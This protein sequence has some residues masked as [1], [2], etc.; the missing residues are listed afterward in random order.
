MA[1]N[2][3]RL[4]IA[5]RIG[6]AQVAPRPLTQPQYTSGIVVG[7]D[8]A[9]AI[10]TQ[11]VATGLTLSFAL[12]ATAVTAG[13]AIVGN[14]QVTYTNPLTPNAPAVVVATITPQG[15]LLATN[16]TV[17][18]PVYGTV[19][20]N[21]NYNLGNIVYTPTVTNGAV[22][23]QPTSFYS[24][25]NIN[26]PITA[27]VSGINQNVGTIIYTPTY[28]AATNT[29]SLSQA[30]FIGARVVIEQNGWIFGGVPTGYN[31]S[32]NQITF[33]IGNF[34]GATPQ[35]NLPRGSPYLN[36]TNFQGNLSLAAFGLGSLGQPITGTGISPTGQYYNIATVNQP[37][38]TTTTVGTTTV[39]TITVGTS[40]YSVN[41]NNITGLY[42]TT[43]P[44]SITS[45]ATLNGIAISSNQNLIFNN[46]TGLASY[47]TSYTATLPSYTAT[48]PTGPSVTG[49]ALNLNYVYKNTIFNLSTT[50]GTITSTPVQ[51]TISIAPNTSISLQ[52]NAASKGWLF[53]NNQTTYTTSVAGTTYSASVS[54]TGSVSITQTTQTSP[55]PQ[56]NLILLSSTATLPVKPASGDYTITSNTLQVEAPLSSTAT[57]PV[58]PASGDYTITSNTLQVASTTYP[59]PQHYP[60]NPQVA[61]IQSHQIRY[62]WEQ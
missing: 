37:A 32:T 61:I 55:T 3:T 39:G 21:T 9:T 38:Q 8:T 7:T 5:P 57:L 16:N 48:L 24:S 59:Q 44:A 50:N 33:S 12:G 47:E 27:S 4:G 46:N 23:L 41:L 62:T 53:A 58:K 43:A 20:T 51:E 40:T 54:P 60:L 35:S 31:A 49:T 36:A 15:T 26:Q 42:T 45:T 34:L 30:G 29:V 56:A 17:T 6:Q 25:G 14:N 22:G 2:V 28:N 10:P 13:F 18:S 19:G 1:G 52:Y 11:K